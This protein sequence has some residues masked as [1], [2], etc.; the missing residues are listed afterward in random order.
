M[1]IEWS[2]PMVT[3]MAPPLRISETMAWARSMVVTAAP[4]TTATSPQSAMR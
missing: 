2:P 1:V 4:G 3:G